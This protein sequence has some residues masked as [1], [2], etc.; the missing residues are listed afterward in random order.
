MFKAPAYVIISWMFFLLIGI[1]FGYSYFFY[2]NEHPINCVIKQQ[3][4][5]NCATCGFSRSF[6][7]YTHFNI[8]EGKSYNSYS[9]A[10]FLFFLF[11][12]FIRLSVILYYFIKQKTPSDSFVKA[13]IAIS[14]SAFLLAFLPIIFNT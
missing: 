1:V 10:A 8:A 11:Q 4:G 6:S 14:I 5:K 12:F 13:D 3:T 7:H 2:P 9:W